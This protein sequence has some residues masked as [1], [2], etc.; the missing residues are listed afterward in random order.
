MLKL[1]SFISV[2][3]VLAVFSEPSFAKDDMWFFTANEIANAYRY[4]QQ[5]GARLRH[6][7]EPQACFQGKKEFAASYQGRKFAAPCQFIG[8]TIRKVRG[9][10]ESAAAMY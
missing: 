3:F 5:F 1:K 7:L 9:L 4:Q 2:A 8:D 10:L 6:P